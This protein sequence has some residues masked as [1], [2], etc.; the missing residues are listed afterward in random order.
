M[1]EENGKKEHD[2][3]K[4]ARKTWHEETWKK[5][6]KRRTSNVVLLTCLHQEV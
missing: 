6:L 2:N 4:H 5:N 3:K 1:E